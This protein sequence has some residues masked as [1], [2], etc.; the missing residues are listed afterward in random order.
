MQHVLLMQAVNNMHLQ[1]M[2]GGETA[3]AGDP[4]MAH[5]EIAEW[6]SNAQQIAQGEGRPGAAVPTEHNAAAEHN[7]SGVT[8]VP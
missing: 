6:T 8:C 7:K 1:H 5:Q 3:P 4:L 2:T